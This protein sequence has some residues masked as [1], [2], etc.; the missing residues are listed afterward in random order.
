MSGNRDTRFKPGQSGNPEGRPA[1]SRSAALVALDALGEESASDIVQAMIDKAKGG[2]AMT[3]RLI[4]ERV[5]PTRKG[6]RIAFN[7]P[8]VKTPADLSGAIASINRQTA[9]GD[10]SP[11]EASLI[12]GLLDAQRKAIETNELAD[13]LAA[14]EKRMLGK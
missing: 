5:W 2:D 14:L 4:L 12:V 6:A 3:G 11:D 7:M 9:D 13:R 8:E 10:I 1:G